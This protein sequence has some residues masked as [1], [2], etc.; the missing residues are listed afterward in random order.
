M[1]DNPNPATSLSIAR[2]TAQF[3]LRAAMDAGSGYFFGLIGRTHSSTIDHAT[4]LAQSESGEFVEILSHN[5]DLKHTIENWLNAGIEPCGIYFISGSDEIPASRG[6]RQ[7]EKD[8]TNC[9]P[10]SPE[11]PVIHM[12]LMLN[13]A[14]CLEAFAFIL[15]GDTARSVPLLLEEDGQESVNR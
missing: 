5:R 7:N 10:H 9:F 4:P 15:D 6:M 8:F 11:T 13:T 1:S 12:P 14:G 2:H 3:I